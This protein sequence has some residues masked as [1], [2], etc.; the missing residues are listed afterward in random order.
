MIPAR[1]SSVHQEYTVSAQ[2]YEQ[3]HAACASPVRPFAFLALSFG[4][5]L[6]HRQ[7]AVADVVIVHFRF[8]SQ[9]SNG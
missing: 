4:H 5:Q 1:F 2:Q 8:P 6:Y 7:P 3:D 9:V